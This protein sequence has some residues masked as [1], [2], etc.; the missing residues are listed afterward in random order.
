MVETTTR[1]EAVNK[2]VNNQFIATI[3][4]N[5]LTEVLAQELDVYANLLINN[6]DVY[7]QAAGLR[8]AAQLLRTKPETELD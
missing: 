3:V 8:K 2:I 6:G 7:A 5:T 1:I 4:T